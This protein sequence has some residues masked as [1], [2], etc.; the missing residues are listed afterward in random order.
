M[1]RNKPEPILKIC[2]GIVVGLFMIFLICLIGGKGIISGWLPETMVTPAAWMAV[3]I[4]SSL[5]A[6][7][8][9]F[10][11]KENKLIGTLAS[12]GVIFLILLLI[13]SIAFRGQGYTFAGT[14][15][16]S[17]IPAAIIGVFVTQRRPKRKY[18]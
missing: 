3:T 11:L 12:S 6:I 1:K 4:G 2:V 15:I 9:G 16:A 10:W 18:R 14:A 13:H 7:I 17:M 8:T 5:A